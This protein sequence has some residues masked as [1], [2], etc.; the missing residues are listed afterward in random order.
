MSRH[1]FSCIDGHTCGNPVRLVAGG[2]PLLKGSTMME[3]RA[4]FLA[5]HDWIRKGLMFEPRGHDMMSRLDPLSADARRL[6][7]R[8]PVHRDLGLPL[9]VRPRHH[10]HGDDGDRERPDD[11]EDAGRACNLDVPAGKVVAEYTM[12]GEYVD[13]VRITNVPSF[14]HSRDLEIDAP[15]LGKLKVDVAYGGN[16]YCIVDPQENFSD[17]ADVSV[18]DLLRWSPVLRTAMN[19]RYSSSIPRTTTSSGCTHI[20]WTGKPQKAGL[21]GAQR[22]VLRRQGDRPLALR[23]RHLGAHGA[24]VRRAASSRSATP[25]STNRSSARSS[26]AG[27]R[28]RCGSAMSTA[29][30]PRSP[31][32]RGRPGSTPSSSTTATRSRTASRWSEDGQFHVSQRCECGGGQ[33]RRTH[34]ENHRDQS[35][36]GRPAAPRGPLQLVGRQ[37]H[38]GV[39]LDRGRGRDRCRHHRLCR[40]L[41]A[42]LGLSAVLRQGRA[43]RPR[44]DRAEADRPRPDRP[45]AAQ[46][47]HGRG[48]ARPPLRE[49]ADRH[50]LLGYSRARSRACRST[51]C[52]AAPSRT[53]IALYR[54]ISQ[55][56]SGGDGARRSPA[57]APRATRN[58]SSRSAAT[59]TTTSRA[60]GPAAPSCSRPTS[61]S[62]TPIP[63]GPWPMRR[64]W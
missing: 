44:R 37:F 7:H 14:L 25:S 9:H 3:R 2:G 8:D 18:G 13:E 38:G 36:P 16:F 5:N 50:R 17:L 23:H 15:G 55:E 43:R 28:R 61:S 11:A 30:S 34:N 46:P 22:R 21:D 52:W 12:D 64:A 54:A 20:M 49:G 63:A 53:T 51:S 42:R 26:R 41:P 19:E 24:V 27:S 10:R 57:I 4:D 59:P 56:D 32:G 62:P 1:T 6:R 35:L 40:M 47:P 31:A 45:L 58:S 29:S 33:S 48:A 39:R 60:S